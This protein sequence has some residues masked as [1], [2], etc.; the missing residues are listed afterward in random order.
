MS[1]LDF[2]ALRNTPP[3]DSQETLREP[4]AGLPGTRRV[5]CG[6][7]AAGY[8]GPALSPGVTRGRCTSGHALTCRFVAKV[9]QPPKSTYLPPLAAF[10]YLQIADSGSTCVQSTYL[11]RNSHKSSIY[12]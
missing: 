4:C 3:L 10:W 5:P 6:P 1:L 11:P 12:P 7:L 2:P 8:P 9:L